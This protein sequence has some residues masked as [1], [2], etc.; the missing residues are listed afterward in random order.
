M[1]WQAF[2]IAGRFLTRLPLPDAKDYSLEKI[3]QS[4]AY[5][6]LIGLVLGGIIVTSALLLDF[7]PLEVQA[8][9][10]LLIWIWLTGALHLDGFADTV[11]AWVGGLGDKKRTLEI[12][13]DPYAGSIAVVAL[14]L[15]LLGKW[16]A[17]KAVISQ[18][19]IV[20]LLWIPVVSRC[21][22]APFFMYSP[23]AKA[24]GMGV[25]VAS[26]VSYS[27]VW[28]IVF[29]LLIIGGWHLS[30]VFMGLLVFIGLVVF[31]IWRFVVIKRLDG[32]TGDTAGALVELM[33]LCLLLCLPAF[34]LLK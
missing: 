33:E 8:F 28:L 7:M 20:F 25:N 9:L 15:L 23:Y 13:K 34:S 17:I 32:V 24:T 27:L 26:Y 19:E 11:D 6:P 5:Y 16:I 31:S 14:V 2:L 21:F 29:T 1:S 4:A 18:E 22:L 3:G 10:V 12:M 30:W